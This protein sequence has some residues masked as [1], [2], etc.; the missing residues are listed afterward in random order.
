MVLLGIISAVEKKVLAIRSWIIECY[1]LQL[2]WF[3]FLIGIN[4]VC[5]ESER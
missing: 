5:Y 4:V 2:L 3:N 1:G